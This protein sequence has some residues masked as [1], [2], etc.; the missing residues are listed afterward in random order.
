MSVGKAHYYVIDLVWCLNANL[1]NVL[2]RDA[3]IKNKQIGERQCGYA[4]LIVN[5][6]LRC[7]ATSLR[8]SL[9]LILTVFSGR[10]KRGCF[11]IF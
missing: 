2:P 4:V 8:Q 11:G 10:P 9:L 3:S 6:C 1:Y 7:R 5:P